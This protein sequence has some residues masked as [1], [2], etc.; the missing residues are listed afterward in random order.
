MVVV[1]VEV[2]IIIVIVVVDTTEELTKR[3][4]LLVGGRVGKVYRNE[5]QQ[6]ISENRNFRFRS[7]REMIAVC[8]Q[9]RDWQAER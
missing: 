4:G 6:R 8:K 2:V 7:L 1:V 5:N 3:R 9:G